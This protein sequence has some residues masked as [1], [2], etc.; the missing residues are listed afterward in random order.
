MN[1]Q[2]LVEEMVDPRLVA[3]RQAMED[4]EIA[5]KYGRYYRCRQY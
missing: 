5:T 3:L 1:S 4:K 2:D